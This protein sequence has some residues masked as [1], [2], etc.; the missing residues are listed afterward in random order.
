MAITSKEEVI[1]EFNFDLKMGKLMVKKI[2]RP[3]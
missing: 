2:N 1:Q 3:W